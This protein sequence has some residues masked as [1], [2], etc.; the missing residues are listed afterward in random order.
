MNRMA[1]AQTKAKKKNVP[2]RFAK[3]RKYGKI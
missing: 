2:V 1:M 3:L